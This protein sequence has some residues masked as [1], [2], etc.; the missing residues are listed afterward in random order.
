MM[1]LHSTIH[2]QLMAAHSG[3]HSQDAPYPPSEESSQQSYTY[4]PSPSRSGR[5]IAPLPSF[6]YLRSSGSISTREH[7][8]PVTPTPR[9][10][11]SSRTLPVANGHRH[12]PF[13]DAPNG[14]GDYGSQATQ[15]IA[16]LTA[17]TESLLD[18]CSSLKELMQQQLE[19]S[20]ARTELMR[21]E[22]ASRGEG[23]AGAREKQ[24]F[25]KVNF[26]TEILKNGPQNED[27]KKAAIE[28]LT[29]YLMRDL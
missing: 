17:V 22:A 19:E 21:A 24:I 6:Q 29:K 4:P 18:V 5:N 13:P 8:T 14:P 25:E 12:S 16:Q 28:C 9:R 23:G 15:A 11:S 27:I 10:N 2:P 26:A 1:G 3:H 7:S 20:K